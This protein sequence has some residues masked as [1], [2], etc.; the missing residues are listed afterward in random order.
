MLTRATCVVNGGNE[1]EAAAQSGAS[2]AVFYNR[3]P[4]ELN[5]RFEVDYTA[6]QRHS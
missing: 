5:L 3:H 4:R 6:N 2:D 1:K